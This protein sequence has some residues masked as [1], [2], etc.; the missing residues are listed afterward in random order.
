MTLENKCQNTKYIKPELSTNEPGVS[1]S[2][3]H[4]K[5]QFS[6]INYVN[7]QPCIY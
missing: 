1:D 7:K 3:C 4:I 2:L 5:N 6:Q